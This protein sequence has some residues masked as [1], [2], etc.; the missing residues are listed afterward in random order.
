[1]SIQ[2]QFQNRK[3]YFD[4]VRASAFMIL[5]KKYTRY[6]TQSKNQIKWSS[7]KTK[8]KRNT[9]KRQWFDIFLVSDDSWIFWIPIPLNRKYRILGY[10][11]LIRV[12][13]RNRGMISNDV[14]NPDWQSVIPWISDSQSLKIRFSTTIHHKKA[15]DDLCQPLWSD[16][17]DTQVTAR[18]PILLLLTHSWFD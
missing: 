1:M 11:N 9:F 15:L 12:V 17:I 16:L 10:L 4:S 2:D 5:D 18:S 14:F 13:Y 8:W 3:I 6:A 7:D